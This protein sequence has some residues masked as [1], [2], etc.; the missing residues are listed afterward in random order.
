MK[1]CKLAVWGRRSD[2]CHGQTFNSD[3][4]EEGSQQQ[5]NKQSK[6]QT[7]GMSKKNSAN[8][9]EREKAKKKKQQKKTRSVQPRRNPVGAGAGSPPPPAFFCIFLLRGRGAK[10]DSTK[11]FTVVRSDSSIFRMVA[12][13][14]V[15]RSLAPDDFCPLASFSRSSRFERLE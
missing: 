9:P 15:A 10:K 6:T 2:L 13:P 8:N 14:D 3:H 4:P 5:T 1:C 12:S 7:L 11:G